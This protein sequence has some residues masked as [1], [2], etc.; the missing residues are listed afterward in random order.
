MLRLRRDR[1]EYDGW[2]GWEALRIPMCNLTIIRVCDL[3]GRTD[4]GMGPTIE[5]WA[6]RLQVCCAYMS[7]C[8]E[9]KLAIS[10]FTTTRDRVP[11]PASPNA[12]SNAPS[13][14]ELHSTMSERYFFPFFLPFTLPCGCAGPPASTSTVSSSLLP[15]FLGASMA[16]A[17]TSVSV[18]FSGAA[19]ISFMK[20]DWMPDRLLSHQLFSLSSCACISAVR[21]LIRI[22]W[23]I[24]LAD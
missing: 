16:F 15:V 19:P 20:S 12:P 21:C 13:P 8:V 6:V 11:S 3:G 23:L 2:G 7:I 9:S 24:S 5:A 10:V 1:D 18:V 17:G 22:F 14:R 4:M